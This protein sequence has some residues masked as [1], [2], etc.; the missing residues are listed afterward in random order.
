MS[1]EPQY[2]NVIL[3]G[4]GASADAGV[5][6]L[7][8]FV[9][10]MWE[11]AI[12]EKVGD[13]PVYGEDLEI[14]KEAQKIRYSLEE[15]ANRAYFDNSNLEDILSLLA[16]QALYGEGERRNFETMVQ[17]VART[18]ELSCRFQY[19]Q[20]D[21]PSG[22]LIRPEP[23]IQ[24][25]NLY[26]ALWRNLLVQ[27]KQQNPLAIITFNYDMVLERTLADCFFETKKQG[28]P[29]MASCAF[30]YSLPPNDFVIYSRELRQ[31]LV[32]PGDI[33]SICGP[34]FQH[35]QFQ[36][37][38]KTALEIPYFKLH[39]SLN[40]DSYDTAGVQPK[41]QPLN[42]AKTP[43]ILPPVF[44]KMKTGV[45]DNIWAGALKVLRSAKHI[46]IVG[47]SLPRTDIY[48][49]YFL[50]SAVGPN[51]DLQKVIVFNPALYR[52]DD[53]ATDM[54]LRYS[55]CFSP[56]FNKRIIFDPLGSSGMSEDTRGTFVH[57]GQIL[58]AKPKE[59]FF[60]P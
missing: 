35:V 48:M 49:Q 36:L 56:Q 15:Y 5:P 6:M 41:H 22:G 55:E 9:D 40:W 59:L 44:N 33:A 29:R 51:K 23:P 46:I 31:T 21:L 17:A 1:E 14:L 3:F 2:H 16:F 27:Y 28:E 38:D 39:G 43:L 8:S 60:L 7:G 42:V 54:K 25:H 24:A 19:Q 37:G 52:N 50:K 34:G 13:K 18:I 45:V 32:K 20:S 58:H 53:E 12:R 57:F 26:S 47:Y 4:A 30:K 10:K 11:Y